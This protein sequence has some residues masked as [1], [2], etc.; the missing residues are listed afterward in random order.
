MDQESRPHLCRDFFPRSGAG[1]DSGK[2]WLLVVVGGV[3]FLVA[4]YL[5]TGIK[6]NLPG[7]GEVLISAEKVR[8]PGHDGAG[9]EFYPVWDAL[10][11]NGFLLANWHL[12]WYLAL[13]P[14]LVALPV[15]WRDRRVGALLM[16]AAGGLGFLFFIFFFNHQY[17][18]WAQDYTTINRAFLHL[19][20]AL[21][22]V[23]GALLLR[24]LEGR[25]VRS[26]ERGG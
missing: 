15:T 19:V 13:P 18:R 24:V 21:V 25:C 9:L 22:L 7:I 8:L 10:W 6:F 12:F 17:S 26:R 4:F 23:E 5:T 2:K 11:D 20:P 14:L 3:A 1:A 16:L